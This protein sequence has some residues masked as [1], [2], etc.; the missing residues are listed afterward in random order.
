ML[1][2]SSIETKPVKLMRLLYSAVANTLYLFSPNYILRAKRYKNSTV[3]DISI[4]PTFYK[5][6]KYRLG[7]I[8]NNP[9]RQISLLAGG[10]VL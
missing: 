6:T 8:N 1:R 2:N 3:S 7:G 5:R 10:P 9:I 4:Y